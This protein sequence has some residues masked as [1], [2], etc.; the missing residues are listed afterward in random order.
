MHIRPSKKISRSHGRFQD[1]NVFAASK[2]KGSAADVH[3]SLPPAKG[4]TIKI[5]NSSIDQNIV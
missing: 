1:P 5:I 4:S 2:L 3:H